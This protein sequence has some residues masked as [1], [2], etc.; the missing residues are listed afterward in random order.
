MKRNLYEVNSVSS[1]NEKVAVLKRRIEGFERM[2]K[3]LSEAL[4]R[5]RKLNQPMENDC[6]CGKLNLTRK[7][8]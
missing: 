2:T 3:T 8:A 1:A 5:E 7:A 4:D 6:V